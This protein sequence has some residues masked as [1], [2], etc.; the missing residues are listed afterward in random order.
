M[1]KSVV[2]IVQQGL[3][4]SLVCR[5]VQASGV[6]SGVQLSDVKS[7]ANVKCAGWCEVRVDVSRESIVRN[8]ARKCGVKSG[9]NVWCQ[10][11][12]ESLV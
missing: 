11:C 12:C 6:K 2:A 5:L 8:M 9:V 3:V 10:G 4:W 1:C 7:G